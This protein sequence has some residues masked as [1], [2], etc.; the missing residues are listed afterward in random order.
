MEELQSAEEAA[1]TALTC[2][3]CMKLFRNP[4][5]MVPCGHTFCGD[6]CGYSHGNSGEGGLDV[7]VVAAKGWGGGE[8]QG[9]DTNEHE[10]PR[11]S[12]TCSLCQQDG[13]GDGGLPL[14]VLRE[15]GLAPNRAVA[16]LLG[17]FYFKRQ[18]LDTLKQIGLVLWQ[19]GL[20]V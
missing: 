16:A 14:E 6:C 5:V 11:M 17:N 2:L 7:E 20:A 13:V 4:L 10:T 18:C 15:G 9:G 1:E 12:R 3:K 8:E 19:E